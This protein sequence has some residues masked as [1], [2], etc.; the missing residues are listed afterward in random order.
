LLFNQQDTYDQMGADSARILT[1]DID[2]GTVNVQTYVLYA[3]QFLQDSDNSF[4]LETD[5]RNDLAG[6]S[7]YDLL[8]IAVLVVS[9]SFAAFCSVYLWKARVKK[10]LLRRL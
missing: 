7:P 8:V 1:F 4:T 2:N 9:L 5:F 10:G 6:K 3:S